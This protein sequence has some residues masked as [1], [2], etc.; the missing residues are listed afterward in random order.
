VLL[1]D[2]KGGTVAKI[3]QPYVSGAKVTADILGEKRGP[4]VRVVKFNRRKNYKR[5]KGHRQDHLEVKVTAI[6]G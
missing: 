2:E 6:S 1:G 3:G 4:K 5:I